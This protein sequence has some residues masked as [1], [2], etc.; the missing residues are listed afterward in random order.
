LRGGG[1]DA[2]EKTENEGGRDWGSI[3]D[4]MENGTLSPGRLDVD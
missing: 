2:R 4:G 3:L 1:W